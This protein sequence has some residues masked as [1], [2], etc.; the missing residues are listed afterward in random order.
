M[1][2]QSKLWT[3]WIE[4]RSLIIF[5]LVMVVFRSAIAD[6]N[7]VPTGS[8]KPTILEGDRVVV[9]K[10]AYDLKVPFTTWHLTEWADPSRGEVVTFY[11]PLDEKL[12]IK[13]VIGVPE[14]VIS[15]RNNQL[16]INKE[17]AT[18]SRLDDDI[19]NQLDAYQRHRHAF[20]YEHFEDVMYPVMLRPSLPNNYNSFGPIKIPP[21]FYLM[22]GDNRDNS[23]DSR[24]IG[25][26]SRNRII[27]RAHTVA[28]SVDYEDY[29]LPRA[30]RFIRP[31]P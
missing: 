4:W 22:L 11:S 26:I 31:L 5:L 2:E 30:D 16:F 15:M 24:R 14:D 6:W 13:R 23:R 9:N 18:Y 12:L 17:P 27:G 8:M 28:F 1:N 20:F 10:L 25:L 3:I 7:Q 19:V 21:G 29:Y